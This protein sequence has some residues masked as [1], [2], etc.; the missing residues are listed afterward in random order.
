METTLLRYFE[1]LKK[2]NNKI[3]LTAVDDEEG[4]VHKHVE[5]IYAALPYLDNVKR[6]IDLGTGAGLPG[7]ILKIARPD[8]DITLLDAT[9]KKVAFCSEVIRQLNLFKIQA[10]WGRA[11]DEI[12]ARAV[13]RFD[14]VISRATWSLK[15]YLPIAELYL[16]GSGRVI[17]MKGPRWQEELIDA[18]KFLKASNLSLEGTH[19]YEL[20]GG[21]KRCLVIFALRQIE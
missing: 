20:S 7:I 9:R 17:A 8:L 16:R 2:W 21:D 5:D 11:Q 15:E 19:P 14:L 12:L 4:F 13:G 18:A 6:V 3:N 10:V 1:L